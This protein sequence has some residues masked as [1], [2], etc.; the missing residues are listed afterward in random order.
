[1]AK[2]KPTLTKEEAQAAAKALEVLFTTEYISKKEL[3]KSNF[4]RGIF[5]SIGTVIGA[6]FIITFLLWVLSAFDELP[7]IGEVVKGIQSSIE[8]SQPN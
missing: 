8:S 3:Y 5:F 4:L 1:M 7:Y 2:Q 6:A